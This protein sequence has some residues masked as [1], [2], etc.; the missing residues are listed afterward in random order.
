MKRFNENYSLDDNEMDLTRALD[1]LR[2]VKAKRTASEDEIDID[3]FEECGYAGDLNS[4][5]NGLS[6]MLGDAFDSIRLLSDKQED[7]ADDIETVSEEVCDISD[8]QS[9]MKKAI[10]GLF[11][12]QILLSLIY[13]CSRR[14]L[15]RDGRRLSDRMV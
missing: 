3:R 12:L 1:E 10:A 2:E 6:C 14:S 9:R 11:G 8:D 5:I 7:Q 13:F 4:R 15:V